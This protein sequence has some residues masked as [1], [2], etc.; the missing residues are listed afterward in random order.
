MELEEKRSEIGS[1]GKG[2][3][4]RRIVSSSQFATRIRF[5]EGVDWKVREDLVEEEGLGKGHND[6]PVHAGWMQDGKGML[7]GEANMLVPF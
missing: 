1:R 4:L 2:T 3:R 7:P 5:P 6:T